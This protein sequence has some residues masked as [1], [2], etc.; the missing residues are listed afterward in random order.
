MVP[1][2]ACLAALVLLGGCA[3]SVDGFARRHGLETSIVEGSGYRHVVVTRYAHQPAGRLHVYIEGDGVPWVRGVEPAEDPTPG[4]PL[5]LRLMATD[6]AD[7]AYLGR[8]CYFGLSGDDGCDASSWTSGRYSSAVVASMA[9]AVRT[10]AAGHG[11]SEVVLIGF[12]GGG[13]IARL[14][15]RHIP[16]LAGLLTVNANLDVHQWAARHGYLPLTDSM[17]PVD[18]ARL[19]PHILHVQ[20]VGA[21]DLVVPQAITESYR[22]Q[23]DDLVVWSYPEFDHVCCWLESWPSI[24]QRFTKQLESREQAI[25]SPS[26]PGPLHTANAI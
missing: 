19:P 7:A 20:A 13:V 3:F 22:R 18:E 10:L 17:S 9:G 15:A 26:S 14:M 5:A 24:L 4:N 8:P 2:W 16:E 21:R 1:A 23:H 6:P 11:Y 25:V 12:S